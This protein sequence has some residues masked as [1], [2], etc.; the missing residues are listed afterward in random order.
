MA[1]GLDSVGKN[2]Q[3]TFSL[4]SAAIFENQPALKRKTFTYN[5]GH[6]SVVEDRQYTG[7]KA[8]K[9]FMKLFLKR[10]Q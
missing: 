10:K 5:D 3:G 1:V 2:H 6:L 7:D 4:V 8:P 9:A